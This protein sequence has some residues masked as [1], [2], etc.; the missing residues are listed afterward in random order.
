M[1]TKQEAEVTTK[2]TK[3]H[4]IEYQISPP[5][6]VALVHEVKDGASSI[7]PSHHGC[8]L[9]LLS[10]VSTVLAVLLLTRLIIYSV[11]QATHIYRE[12]PNTDNTTDCMD[13]EIIKRTSWAERSGQNIFR[14]PNPTRYVLVAHSGGHSCYNSNECVEV[15]RELQKLHMLTLH[16]P[17]IG[18]NFL[19]GGDGKVYEGRGWDSASYTSGFMKK[20]SIVVCFLGNYVESEPTPGQL[21][22][23]QELIQYGIKLGKIAPYYKLIAHSQIETTPSPGEKILKVIDKWS[24]RCL[25]NCWAKK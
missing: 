16:E 14:L 15:L 1:V 9:W 12:L 20:R 22:A 23:L 11:D 5:M 10:L 8:K 7:Q 21:V 6:Y 13:L 24:Q 3:G 2:V 25:H 18:W 4:G 17:Q 19:I